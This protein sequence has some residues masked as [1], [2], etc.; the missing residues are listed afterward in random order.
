MAADRNFGHVVGAELPI[1]L[2][3]DFFELPHPVDTPRIEVAFRLFYTGMTRKE[4]N[5]VVEKISEQFRVWLN[6]DKPLSYDEHE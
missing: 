3:Q 4:A 2:Q 6:Y 1:I 5:V